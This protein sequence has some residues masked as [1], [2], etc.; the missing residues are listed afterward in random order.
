ML[1]PDGMEDFRR[2]V[3][4]G[5][6]WFIIKSQAKGSPSSMFCRWHYSRILHFFSHLLRSLEA[7]G[8]IMMIGG[9]WFCLPELQRNSA[10]NHIKKKQ[11]QEE[12]T[13]PETWIPRLSNM[14]ITSWALPY[15][16]IRW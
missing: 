9:A 8:V 5:G 15:A 11:H 6:D 3:A 4:V 1:D 7:G 2:Y 12:Q 10:Q 14:N 16:S 13:L